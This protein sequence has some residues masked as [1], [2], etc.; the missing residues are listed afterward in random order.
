[1]SSALSP[2]GTPGQQT[3]P[4]C[5]VMSGGSSCGIALALPPLLS[6]RASPL[7][8]AR[9]S[10]PAALAILLSKPWLAPP[11]PC[12]EAVHSP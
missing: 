4:T 10:L 11:C 12:L 9:A 3:L 7:F 2:A 5:S 1:M 8:R 6:A